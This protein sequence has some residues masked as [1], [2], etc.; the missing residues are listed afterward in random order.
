AAQVALRLAPDPRLDRPFHAWASR[1]RA[2]LRPDTPLRPRLG[3]RTVRERLAAGRGRRRHRRRLALPRARPLVPAA[4]AD[5]PA[6]LAAAPLR[7]LR[8]LRPRARPR[9]D[10]RH[11]PPWPR[12]PP[13]RRP[14]RGARDLARLRPDPASAHPANQPAGDAGRHLTSTGRKETTCTAF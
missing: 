14:R 7:H 12:R 13:P 10:G 9:A 8:C 6:R 2:A 4:E 3:A 11:R 5:R 1:R